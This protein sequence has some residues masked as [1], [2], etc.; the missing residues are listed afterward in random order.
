MALV[1]VSQA[2]ALTGKNRSTVIRAIEKGHVS[3]TRDEFGH[4]LIDPAELERVYGALRNPDA[5]DDDARDDADQRD[6][7]ERDGAASMREIEL[8]REMLTEA[9][10]VHERTRSDHERERRTWEEERAF[11]RSMLERNS[12][13]IKLLTDQ[14]DERE[15]VTARPRLPL[16]ARMF[17]RG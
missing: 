9:R 7:S 12:E 14:R 5:A 6:A 1:T 15:R 13:Q 17:G 16:L 3:A 10:A 8:L 2:A 11:L 4:Y